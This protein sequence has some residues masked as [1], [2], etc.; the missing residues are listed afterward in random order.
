MNADYLHSK[1]GQKKTKLIEL[2][3]PIHLLVRSDLASVIDQRLWAVG[4]LFLNHSV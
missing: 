4:A 2:L 3:E 1:Y